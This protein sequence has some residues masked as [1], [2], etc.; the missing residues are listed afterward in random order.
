MPVSSQTD[1][2][3]TGIKIQLKAD[4]VTATVAVRQLFDNAMSDVPTAG[5]KFPDS[6]FDA[7]KSIVAG[8]DQLMHGA[9][10]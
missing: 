5:R 8:R 9:R 10:L 3:Q 6:A 7:V 1:A 2:V 4:G